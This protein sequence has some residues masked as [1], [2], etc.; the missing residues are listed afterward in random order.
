[1]ALLSP[2][3][4]GSTVAEPP[5][6]TDGARRFTLTA[7]VGRSDGLF[8]DSGDIVDVA[9]DEPGLADI[10]LRLGMAFSL[11]GP[12]SG[13]V[14]CAKDEGYASVGDIPAETADCTWN[15][16]FLSANNVDVDRGVVRDGY[17]MRDRLG[18]LH[19]LLVVEH[20]IDSG[21]MGTATLE[22]LAAE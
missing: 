17:V 20:R 18:D 14:F 4:C 9:W 2:T 1:L 3:A 13:M 10:I 21:G 15:H 8:L 7:E 12:A 22:V 19:R 6:P 5:D 11:Q 16:V